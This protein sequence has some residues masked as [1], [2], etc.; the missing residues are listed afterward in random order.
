M[1]RENEGMEDEKGGTPTSGG[2]RRGKHHFGP[3]GKRKTP[4]PSDLPDPMRIPREKL[5]EMPDTLA[6]HGDRQ[7]PK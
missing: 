2:T 5:P 7:M 1:E 6:G 4:S 3:D